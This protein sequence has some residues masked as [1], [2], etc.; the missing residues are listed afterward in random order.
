MYEVNSDNIAS[1]LLASFF[2][3]VSFS[4]LLSFVSPWALFQRSSAYPGPVAEVVLVLT[5]SLDGLE[6]PADVQYSDVVRLKCFDWH[7]TVAVDSDL[8]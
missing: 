7:Q 8:D 2:F 3:V 4:A 1:L 6:Y 5:Q